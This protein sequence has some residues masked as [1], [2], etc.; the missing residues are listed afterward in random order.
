NAVV[1]AKRLQS[2]LC[3]SYQI[4]GHQIVIGISL[5]IALAPEHGTSQLELLKSADLALYCAK[6]GR[7][8]F[9][10]YEPQM[11]SDARQRRELEIDLREAVAKNE[12]VLHYQTIVDVQSRRVCGAEALVRWNHPRRGLL[13]PDRFIPIAEELGLIIP[14]GEWILRQA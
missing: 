2:T 9:Q 6:S 4:D 13:A 1:L 8:G 12:F 11:D 7:L 14:I 5:G 3:E 10:F